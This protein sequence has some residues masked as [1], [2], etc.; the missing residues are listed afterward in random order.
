MLAALVV[1]VIALAV[2]AYVGYPLL[3][4]GRNPEEEEP[5]KYEFELRSAQ[6]AGALRE[7]ETDHSLGK[8]ADDDFV[9]RRNR[10]VRD[11]QSIEQRPNRREPSDETDV[12]EYAE[13]L[14]AAR[15]AE[16]KRVE[17]GLC[18]KCGHSNPST[19]RFCMNC[20]TRLDTREPAP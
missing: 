15:R 3:F 4:P 18:R 12:E 10:L 1:F 5:E 8:I 20:G 9:E 7:L 11:L 17:P 19:A 2:G 14:I 13:R 6:R 16:K